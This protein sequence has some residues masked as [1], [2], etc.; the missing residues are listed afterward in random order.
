MK[1]KSYGTVC[2][3]H[4]QRYLTKQQNKQQQ[5]KQKQ[6]QPHTHTHTHT[7]TNKPKEAVVG[8]RPTKTSDGVPYTRSHKFSF[9]CMGEVLN[10]SFLWMDM[11]LDCSLSCM[12]VALNYWL[13]CMGME[14]CGV[15]WYSAWQMLKIPY[16]ARGHPPPTLT[17][18]LSLSLTHTHTHKEAVVGVRPTKTSDSVPHTLSQ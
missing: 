10:C 6:K 14:L 12:G 5:S 16:G 7:H 1:L 9:S 11:G 18:S 17:L 13:P 15:L 3:E 8:V 4:Y 2:T